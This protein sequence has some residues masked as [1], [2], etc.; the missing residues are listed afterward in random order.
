L[1]VRDALKCGHA[2][3]QS[4]EMLK[5]LDWYLTRL[6]RPGEEKDTGKDD[7]LL[8]GVPAPGGP[9]PDGDIVDLDLDSELP[10]P[11][12]EGGELRS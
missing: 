3:A 7:A 2:V 4:D 9:A 8:G 6:P 10:M 11:G 5:E 12:E 1:A